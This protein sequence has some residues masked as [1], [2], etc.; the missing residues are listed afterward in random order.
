MDDENDGSGTQRTNLLGLSRSFRFE[1]ESEDPLERAREFYQQLPQP[2]TDPFM[3]LVG[4]LICHGG[5]SSVGLANEAFARLM[6]DSGV[7]AGNCE[8]C[9]RAFLKK[10]SDKRFCRPTC[11]VQANRDRNFS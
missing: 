3:E 5:K 10:S 1:F 7:R 4:D 6:Q 2:L 9:G 8:R 11:R